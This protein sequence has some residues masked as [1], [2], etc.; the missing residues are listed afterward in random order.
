MAQRRKGITAQ[1][2]NG[3]IIRIFWKQL[4]DVTVNLMDRYITVIN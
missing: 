2:L 1:R 3:A 4:R